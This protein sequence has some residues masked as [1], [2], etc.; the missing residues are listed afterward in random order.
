MEILSVSKYKGSTFEIKFSD[1]EN[2][3]VGSATVDN[4]NLKAGL[5]ISENAILEIESFDLLRKAKHRVLYLLEV[6]DYSEFLL[7]KKLARTYPKEIAKEACNFAVSRGYVNDE[8]YAEKLAR[9]LFEVKKVGAFKAKQ[10]FKLA[11]ISPDIFEEI[12]EPYLE[13]EN[14][15]ERLEELV[16]QKYERYLTDEKGVRKVRS[17]LLRAGYSYSDINAVLDLYDLDFSDETADT[18]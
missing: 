12:I 14:A 7:L 17:A 3:Y 1:R 15:F 10:E 2:L 18:E 13:A 16:E 11:G 4:F 6:K 9:H 5:S 8:K